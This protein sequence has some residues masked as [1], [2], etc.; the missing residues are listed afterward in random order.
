[1]LFARTL[2]IF[3]LDCPLYEAARVILID[4]LNQIVD[5]EEI[6]IELLT[7]GKSDLSLEDNDIVFKNV[8][9]FIR[10]SDRF[11]IV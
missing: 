3:S 11:L 5:V 2:S 7:R 8:F 4:N 10:R 6:D 9:D 1:M